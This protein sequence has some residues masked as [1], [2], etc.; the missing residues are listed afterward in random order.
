MVW[1]K[2]SNKSLQVLIWVLWKTISCT[3]AMPSIMILVESCWLVNSSPVW[4]I[5]N[6]DRLVGTWQ[7]RTIWLNQCDTGTTVANSCFPKM[8]SGSNFLE[9]FAISSKQTNREFVAFK[10]ILSLAWKFCQ[11]RYFSFEILS[12]MLF[13][14]L[15]LLF[16]HVSTFRS[17]AVLIQHYPVGNKVD[18]WRALILSSFTVHY[19]KGVWFATKFFSCL[20]A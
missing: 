15:T 18:Q 14:P 2:Q 16:S 1:T 10:L 19:N 11:L 13:S 5:A 7:K 17:H 4:E 12:H 20:T 3:R 8:S 6:Q 9:D